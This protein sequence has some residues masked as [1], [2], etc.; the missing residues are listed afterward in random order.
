M[1]W[2]YLCDAVVLLAGGLTVGWFAH[3][4]H[5]EQHSQVV[6][7]KGGRYKRRLTTEIVTAQV[8]DSARQEGAP[9]DKIEPTPTT[10]VTNTKRRT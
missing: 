3:R 8:L 9:L 10:D 6:A 4:L 5:H 7:K 2:F 1:S